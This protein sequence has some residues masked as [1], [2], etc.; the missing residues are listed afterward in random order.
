MYQQRLELQQLPKK[1]RHNDRERAEWIDNDETL[2]NLYQRHW[3]SKRVWIKEHRDLIDQ[4]IDMRSEKP[5][6]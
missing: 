2:H 5:T 4:V 3:S 1:R 6:R